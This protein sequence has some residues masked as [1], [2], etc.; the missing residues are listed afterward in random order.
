MKIG[1]GCVRQA[2]GYG[3]GRLRL[4]DG[5]F[6]EWGESETVAQW[7]VLKFVGMAMEIGMKRSSS[8]V[9]RSRE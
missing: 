9:E 1:E 3:E 4:Q 2:I 7:L 8:G 6:D 5:V